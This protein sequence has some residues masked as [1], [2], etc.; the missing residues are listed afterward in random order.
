MAS[1]HDQK[2]P[3]MGSAAMAIVNPYGL[4]TNHT[5]KPPLPGRNQCSANRNGPSPE[6]GRIQ[7][8]P[9]GA[10]PGLQIIVSGVVQALFVGSS[11]LY[12]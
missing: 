10:R 9:W 3:I 11:D 5:A 8:D 2:H 12:S 4:R 6:H 7:E 1:G